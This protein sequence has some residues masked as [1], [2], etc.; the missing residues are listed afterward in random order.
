MTD[1][2]RSRDDRSA[3]L[4]SPGGDPRVFQAAQ[5]AATV[6][7]G[8]ALRCHGRGASGMLACCLVHPRGGVRGGVRGSVRGGVRGAALR[9][10]GRGAVARS[11]EMRGVC[12]GWAAVVFRL[13]ALLPLAAEI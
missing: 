5:K 7:G 10:D 6:V 12:T 9:R 4:V 13:V 1:E 11:S 8:A 3:R 2:A